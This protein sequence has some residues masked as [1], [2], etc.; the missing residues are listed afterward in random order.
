MHTICVG[1]AQKAQKLAKEEHC[2]RC[3]DE[4][5]WGIEG[6]LEPGK[7]QYPLVVPGS[8]AVPRILPKP[9]GDTFQQQSKGTVNDPSMIE[10]SS[11]S[12]SEHSNDQA[13]NRTQQDPEG[14]GATRGHPANTPPP[15]ASLAPGTTTAPAS[16]A[17]P[18]HA[19]AP[20]SSIRSVEGSLLAE[21][22]AEVYDDNS[23]NRPPSRPHPTNTGVTADTATTVAPTTIA[24]VALATATVDSI[25]PSTTP[26]AQ[27][28]G[29]LAKLAQDRRYLAKKSAEMRKRAKR[30]YKK[31][32]K[33]HK[34]QLKK[35][36]KKELKKLRT[37]SKRQL[38]MLMK[39][40][41]KL[42]K[43][44]RELGGD[45]RSGNEV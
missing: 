43:R 38:K 7:V 42:D 29:E 22:N 27:I 8:K 23:A 15:T 28:S 30:E 2:W 17:R 5:E 10:G 25:S 14:A 33:K 3:K 18:D 34:K 12:R 37:K 35:E 40:S 24:N 1:V 13:N 21:R 20:T 9:V 4:K 44:A 41:K 32:N 39:E 16:T 31:L 6:H 19:Q 45:R 11:P 26:R 36:L